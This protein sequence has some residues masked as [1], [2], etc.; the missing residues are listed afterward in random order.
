MAN[1]HSKIFTRRHP[2]PNFFIF[3][4]FSWKIGQIIGW[5]PL[6][7]WRP[8]WKIPETDKSITQNLRLSLPERW[9][10]VVSLEARLEVAVHAR[11]RQ[12]VTDNHSVKIHPHWGRW[13]P[14]TKRWHK[15]PINLSVSQFSRWRFGHT[16]R[17]HICDL[18]H[19]KVS[20][21]L[22]IDRFPSW[23]NYYALHLV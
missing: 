8:L 7:G 5:Y 9:L 11:V 19:Q 6:S 2:V 10:W 1:L 20:W 23:R 17:Q 12:G 4:Q 3:I 22:F 18:S 16:Y 15:I 21:K 13:V 14:A